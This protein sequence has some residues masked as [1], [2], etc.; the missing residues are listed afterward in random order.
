MR[1]PNLMALVIALTMSFLS[2]GQV[3]TFSISNPDNSDYRLVMSASYQSNYCDCGSQITE[4]RIISEYDQFGIFGTNLATFL[5]T[6]FNNYP[7]VVGPGL[8]TSIGAW[9]IITGKRTWWGDSGGVFC[10]WTICGLN[11]CP[12]G[13]WFSSDSYAITTAPLKNPVNLTATTGI[14]EDRVILNWG[15]GTNFPNGEHTY[16]VYR[17]NVLIASGLSGHGPYTFT[18]MGLPAGSLHTYK[19]TTKIAAFAGQESSGATVAGSTFSIVASDGEFFNR[20][21]VSWT[22]VPA[23]TEDIRISRTLPAGGIEELA[24]MSKSAKT[25]NDVTGIPGFVYTYYVTPLIGG[26][27]FGIEYS[28]AGYSRPNGTISGY[29]LSTQGAGVLGADVHVELLTT[30]PP[31]GATLPPD[32]PLTYCAVTDASGYYEIRNVFYFTGAQFRIY[33]EFPGPITHVFTPDEVIRTLDENLRVLS[34]VNFTD[35]TVLTVSGRVTYPPNPADNAICGIKNAV[36]LVNDQEAGIR[37]D[38]DGNWQ[39]AITSVGQYSFSVDYNGHAFETPAGDTSYTV[40]VDQDIPGLDFENVTQRTLKIIA[41]G[42]CQA[43]LGDY[44]TISVTATSTTGTCFYQLYQTNAQ[45]ELTITGLPPR[46]YTIELEDIATMSSNYSNMM[47]QIGGKPVDIDLTKLDTMMTITEKDTLIITP[48]DTVYLPG[49]QLVITPADTSIVRVQD[50][51]ITTVPLV[52][53]IYRSPIELIADFEEAG[54]VVTDCPRPLD[55][56]GGNTIVMEQGSQYAMVFL[57]RETLGIECYVDSGMLIIYDEISDRES[58]PVK[59]PI[60]NGLATYTIEAGEP[61]IAVSPLYNHEKFL[62]IVPKIDFLDIPPVT[63]WA[64]VTGIHS[65]DPTF[66]TRTPEIPQLIVHDPPGDNSFA[67]VEKGTSF[68]TF[69]ST[70]VRDDTDVGAFFNLKVG[71]Q[72]KIFGAKFK[73][74]GLLE[75]SF[76]HSTGVNNEDGIEMTTTFLENFSTSTDELF[77]GHEGDVYIGAA[78]N[79]IYA[80]SDELIYDPANCTADV[81]VILEMNATEFATTFIYTEY[82]IKNILLPSIRNLRTLQDTTQDEGR[83]EYNR[84]LRDQRLWENILQDNARNRDSLAVFKENVSVSSGASFSKTAETVSGIKKSYTYESFMQHDLRVGA[85][86]EIDAPVF[87]LNVALGAMATFKTTTTEVRD[88]S[89]TTTRT[90]GYVIQDNDI[91]DFLSIDILQDTVYDVPAFRIVSGTTSCPHEPGTQTRVESDID[92]FPPVVNNVPADGAANFLVSLT[93]TADS[94]E[95]W[96]YFARVISSTNPDGAIIRLAGSIINSNPVGFFLDYQQTQNMILS[97]ERGPLASNYENIGIMMYPACEYEAWQNGGVMPNADT[98]YISVNFQTNCSNVSLVNPVQNWLVNQNSNNILHVT[99]SGYD[100]NN[101]LLESLTLQIKK[102][103]EGYIS[104]VTIPKQALIGPFYDVFMNVSAYEDGEYSIRARA[105]CGFSGGSAYSSEITGIID[106]MSLAPFGTPTP[107]DGFLQQGQQVSVTYDKPIA[108]PINYPVEI[109]LVREDTGEEIPVSAQ[110]SGNTLLLTT[111]PS[112]LDMPE[113]HGVRV[114][115]R[116]H[117]LRD[118]SGNVQKYPVDWSFLVNVR[119]VFWDPDVVLHSAVEG[120]LTDFAG[121]LKNAALLSKSFS[122]QSMDAPAIINYPEWVIPKQTRGTI[123]SNNDYPVV[124]GVQPDLVPGLYSGTITAAVDGMP[125]SMN[126]VYEVLAKPVNWTFDP[127]GYENTMTVVAQFS[128][129]QNNAPL[130]QDTRDRVAA[131]VNGEIRGIANIEYIPENNTY[132]AYLT[133]HSNSSGGGGGETVQFRF[134]KALTGIEYQAVE[135]VNFSPNSRVGSP[136]APYILHPDGIFQIIPLRK[137]WNWISFNKTHTDMTR[138]RLFQSLISGIKTNVITIKSQ[139][140]ST[141]YNPGSGWQGNLKTLALGPGYMVHLS[142]HPD[143]LRVVGNEP[144]NAVSINLSNTWNWIGFPE[145]EPRL[146]DEVLESV[147]V[148]DGNELKSQEAFAVW[149]AVHGH[150]IGSLKMFSPGAG[151]KLRV[152]SNSTLQFRDASRYV[153]QPGLYE[154]NMNVMLSI[155]ETTMPIAPE[156]LQVGAFI[157]G[158]C[159]GVTDLEYVQAINAYR[160]LLLIVGNGIHQNAEVE[161][162]VLNVSTEDEYS[163]VNALMP[164]RIDDIVGQ[165]KDPYVLYFKDITVADPVEGFHLWQS[166]PNPTEGIVTFRYQ[167]DRDELVQLR[168]WNMDGHLIST[169]VDHIEPAGQHRKTADLSALPPGIYTYTLDTPTFRATKKLVKL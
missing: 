84:L 148:V 73:L 54:A 106:R 56:G 143:T 95:T 147:A 49:N 72:A 6:T 33:P 28:D 113:L 58:T 11:E 27:P 39:M 59:V 55:W 92:I 100:V 164:F 63:Y 109:S 64:V 47:D 152:S 75:Y 7:F 156:E 3:T 165:L 91:G 132:A 41:Q 90:V 81:K 42:G 128:L 87:F 26:S 36:I 67:F 31:G 103:G 122:L 125:V 29:V 17:D 69:M 157:D 50:T 5:N 85:E 163:P 111:T 74:V 129:T 126:I 25:Y 76:K 138:E 134:W 120:A 154:F 149:D 16:N 136:S 30:L 140:S 105:N 114:K 116:A 119:P 117:L 142:A 108:C 53:F 115:A 168:I 78:L 43:P 102:I 97:V 137:G 45:G 151:Y 104:Y 110:C 79:Q 35:E 23:T 107:S 21:R 13:D 18:D 61:D 24:I 94:R 48:P 9:F 12:C 127:G 124:F 89:E 162:R 10:V 4:M 77:V 155:D 14:Y 145:Q 38:A 118:L 52:R 15:K 153:P 62:H 161:F 144:Q 83:M 34:G 51:L 19:V 65:N 46:N 131:F 101:P 160:G 80:L 32:C 158:K 99:F 82:H 150:W 98:A 20:T 121:T 22:N 2:T 60:I 70:G 93:N 123:L 86:F 112:L 71:P 130:S 135:T 133:I 44:V 169:I 66:F 1:A 68:T 40:Y 146:V 159:H 57:V 37:T 141:Q 139:S 88:T 166:L 167:L 8:N 96:E